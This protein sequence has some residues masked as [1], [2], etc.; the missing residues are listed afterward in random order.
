MWTTA[1]S[2]YVTRFYIFLREENVRVRCELYG[3]LEPNSERPTQLN[4]TQLNWLSWVGSGALNTLT[5]HLTQLNW[6]ASFSSSEH[7]QLSWVELSRVFRAL[8]APDSTQLNWAEWASVVTQFSSGHMMST[9][10]TILSCCY[11]GCSMLSSSFSRRTAIDKR[12]QRRQ[13]F[14]LHKLWTVCWYCGLLTNSHA[15]FRRWKQGFTRL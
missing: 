10:I 1:K 15:V 2:S 11:W 5:T 3:R 4:S 12:L 6:L 8:R 7:F 9:P 13:I 14:V